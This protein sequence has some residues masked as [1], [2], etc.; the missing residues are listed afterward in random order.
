MFKL[1]KFCLRGTK[2][3]NTGSFEKARNLLPVHI[4]TFPQICIS[5]LFPTKIFNWNEKERSCT[6]SQ[7]HSFLNC[8]YKAQNQ[9]PF[10][11]KGPKKI[12]LLGSLA[13]RNLWKVKQAEA[14]SQEALI[15]APQFGLSTNSLTR[16]RNHSIKW[17]F[18][19]VI[20]NH[21]WFIT[22]VQVDVF[23]GKSNQMSKQ[24]ICIRDD[25]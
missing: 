24:K 14:H 18:W 10:F 7:P 6:F 17:R 9:H 22:L 23:I 8:R 12:Q 15:L 1:P 20:C 5:R 3:A 4:T 13:L 19:G 16:S 25:F 11:C 21:Q 2:F